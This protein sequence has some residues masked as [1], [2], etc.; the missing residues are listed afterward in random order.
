VDRQISEIHADVYPR[1]QDIENAKSAPFGVSAASAADTDAIL[2]ALEQQFNA[3]SAELLA[4]Q[5]L[6]GD[7]GS[8]RSIERS[9]EPVHMEAYAQRKTHDK[10]GT[11]RIEAIL[12]R[13]DPVERAIMT[14]PACTIAGLAVKARHAA[15]VMSHYWEEPIDQI[16]WEAQAIRLLVE[17]VCDVAHRPL[18]LRNLRNDD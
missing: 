4:L 13:L 11:E 10:A 9:P 8:R 2:I 6:S 12:T 5:Q 3:I 17:A 18:L 14:T 1:A 16:D 15:Y 7:A